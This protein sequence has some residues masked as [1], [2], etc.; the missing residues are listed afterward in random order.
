MMDDHEVNIGSFPRGDPIRIDA[1]GKWFSGEAE[2]IHHAVLDL[3]RRSLRP[4]AAGTWELHAGGQTRS[5]DV[6]DTPF[7]VRAVRREGDG[8]Y[9]LTLDD[10]T[11]ERLEMETLRR[12]ERGF[13]ARVKGG[14][15]PARFSRTGYIDLAHLLQEQPDGSLVLP[16]AGRP[17]VGI[18]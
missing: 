18:E 9:I 7:F 12:D 5:V 11:E 6:E 10:G 14:R 4:A 3:L 2:I 1:E 13:R 17:D 15:F 16:V 8:R